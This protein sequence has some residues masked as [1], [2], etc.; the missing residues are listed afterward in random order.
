MTVTLT[1]PNSVAIPYRFYRDPKSGRAFGLASSWKPEGCELVTEGWTV[2]HIDGTTGLGRP[3]FA[4]K[5]E[6]EAWCEAN[7]GFK[8]M[9]RG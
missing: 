6:A 5:A 4:T 2:K 9:S 3:P 7:P 1:K 8:G